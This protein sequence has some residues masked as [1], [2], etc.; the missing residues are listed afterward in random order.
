[1]GEEPL[2]LARDL[3]PSKDGERPIIFDGDTS[4]HRILFGRYPEIESDSSNRRRIELLYWY[5][6]DNRVEEDSF[7]Y[8][9]IAA[10]LKGNKKQTSARE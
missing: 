6:L 9:P 3:E 5:Y 2:F 4:N 7:D 10:L 8:E 1:L